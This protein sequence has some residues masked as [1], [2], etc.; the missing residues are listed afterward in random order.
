MSQPWSLPNN[1]KEVQTLP[2]DHVQ[3][4]SS[5][6]GYSKA[7]VALS[8]ASSSAGDQNS[9]VRVATFRIIQHHHLKRCAAIFVP[10][11]DSDGCSHGI[12]ILYRSFIIPVS[13]SGLRK[14]SAAT[15]LKHWAL[16]YFQRSP[17]SRQCRCISCRLQCDQIWRQSDL[18][19]QSERSGKSFAGPGSADFRDERPGRRRA[20]L[21]CHF[22][23]SHH[24]R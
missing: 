7:H 24:Q 22:T 15:L 3:R 23:P 12:V 16:L 19:E 9:D 21:G 20:R 13:T 10:K 6:L 2:L 8:A 17:C 5:V 11:S 4:L 14:S 1:S 18:G